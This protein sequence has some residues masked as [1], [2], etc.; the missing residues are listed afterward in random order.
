M[1]KSLTWPAVRQRL[2]KMWNPGVEAEK[3]LSKEIRF[4]DENDEL[5]ETAEV[6]DLV[7]AELETRG[8]HYILSDGNVFRVDR[9]YLQRIR[10]FLEKKVVATSLPPYADEESYNRRSGLHVLDRKLITVDG[11]QVELCDLIDDSG[12]LIYVKRRSK[13]STL[14]HLWTQVRSAAYLLRRMNEARRKFCGLLPQGVPTSVRDAI[15]SGAHLTFV[16]AILGTRKIG[17]LPLLAQIPLQALL[18]QIEEWSYSI[19]IELV[20]DAN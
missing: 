10:A 8:N 13:S 18:Q 9:S 1:N 4:F 5:L 17:D 11:S 6:R 20:S 12:R 19:E 14:S 7:I 2:R 16:V 15:E 3:L